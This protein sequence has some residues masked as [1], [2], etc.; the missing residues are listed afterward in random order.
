MLKERRKIVI[1]KSNKK[2]AKVC[3]CDEYGREAWL[4]VSQ[5]KDSDNIEILSSEEGSPVVYTKSQ[6][7][8]LIKE[9]KKI[10]KNMQARGV[11][12]SMSV[13]KTEDGCSTHSVSVWQCTR[14][15]GIAFKPANL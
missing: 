4:M 1:K 13:S 3:G 9:L 2:Y 15:H 5:H 6:I 14:E 7:S 12:G 10:V 8:E 11:N